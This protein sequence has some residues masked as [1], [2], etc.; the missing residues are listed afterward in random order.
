MLWKECELTTYKK[1]SKWSDAT[2]DIVSTFFAS[3]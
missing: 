1:Y 2:N 3:K